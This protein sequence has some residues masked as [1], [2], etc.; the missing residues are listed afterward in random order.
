MDV[1]CPRCQSEYDFDE[2]R[3]PD[4]GVNVKCAQCT[5][6]FR[7]MRS[8]P[9]GPV[10]AAL[11]PASPAREWKVRQPSGNT[12]VCRELTTLQRWIVEG[13]VSRDD[14]I[15][16]T[17]DT[18]KRLG[19][20]PELASFFQVVD[21]AQRARAYDTLRGAPGASAVAPQYPSPP[22]ATVPTFPSP[23]PQPI[24]QSSPSDILA[25]RLFGDEVSTS[26]P[27]QNQE[28]ELSSAL[29]KP[30][31]SPRPP[32]N[33]SPAK[34][35]L[36]SLPQHQRKPAPLS[37]P[38]PTPFSEA[39]LASVNKRAGGGTKWLVLLL[40][41]VGGAAAYYFAVMVPE[42][43]RAEQARRAE[44]ERLAKAE[45]EAAHEA[46]AMKAK[47][48]ADA[49][50]KLVAEQAAF[51]AGVADAGPPEVANGT[52]A[53]SEPPRSARG[54]DAVI[55]QAERLR[56]RERP[57]QALNLFGQAAEMKPE[58]VEP[59]AGRGLTYLD[60]QQPA[61]AEASFDEALKLS[62]RYGPA[63][64]GM[65]ESLRMQGK[66]EKA[67]EWYKRYLEV[68]PDGSEAAVARNALERFK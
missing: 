7:V 25:A 21:E 57:Q 2:A 64:M 9:P 13:K 1:R 35:N 67:I 34:P 43:A 41:L 18:W 62:P 36:A 39:E 40:L 15:S 3:V 23:P 22:T 44:A 17:G 33:A 32:P 4:A 27:A 38:S 53:P 59:H 65:A 63:I 48:E 50:A 54:F 51:D 46:A 20:I 26:A 31:N 30:A 8:E 68:L 12:Y 37:S 11:P 52:E 42:Q 19:N 24:P 66:K 61:A 6:V 55:A 5:F 16:L 58:R 49:A 56:E 47:A 10:A 29:P 45:A 14:E 28:V 60:M